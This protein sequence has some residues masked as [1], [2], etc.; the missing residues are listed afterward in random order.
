MAEAMITIG[1]QGIAQGNIS[2]NYTKLLSKGLRGI[3]DEI[4]RKMDG[5]VPGDIEGTNKLTFW[6]A[7]KISCEAV[8]TFADRYAKLAAQKA[9]ETSDEKRREELLEIAATLKRVP[10]HPAHT[11]IL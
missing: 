10:E 8:I 3:I 4:D 9:A 6:K 11:C 1:G 5:F 7:A 2:I